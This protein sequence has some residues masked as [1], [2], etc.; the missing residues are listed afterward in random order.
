[1]SFCGPGVV[2]RGLVMGV[3]P[4]GSPHRDS[5]LQSVADREKPNSYMRWPF[6]VG[7]DDFIAGAGMDAADD[8]VRPL[9]DGP[10]RVDRE[11]SSSVPRRLLPA[12]SAT[13]RTRLG[14]HSLDV[15]DVLLEVRRRSGKKS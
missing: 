6:A 1:M 12:C 2:D 3:Q 8:R 13:Q 10:V 7:G 15:R 11:M 4:S 9:R 5:A 14:T